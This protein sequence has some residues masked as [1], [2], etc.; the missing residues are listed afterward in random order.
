VYSQSSILPT[1]YH[2]LRAKVS[3][4]VLLSLRLRTRRIK[5]PHYQCSRFFGYVVIPALL[6]ARL[7]V[8][9]KT[10]HTEFLTHRLPT[11]GPADPEIITSMFFLKSLGDNSCQV[12]CLWF[13][14]S[15]S[16]WSARGAR[17]CRL[18]G[19]SLRSRR[20]FPPVFVPP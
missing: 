9:K 4:L 5:G 15:T 17:A 11:R 12:R 18:P 14:T 19:V 6:L 7:R 13:H 10:P 20:W 1:V 8:T 2:S 16:S 3:P